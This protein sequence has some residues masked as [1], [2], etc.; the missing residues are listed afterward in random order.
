MKINNFF[1]IFVII[2]LL[3]G[4]SKELENKSVINE[5]DLDLQVLEAYEEGMKALN[6]GDVL[7]AAQKFNEA[8]T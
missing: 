3:L 6:T 2:F 4:C 1:L 7:Y 5:K 8:E